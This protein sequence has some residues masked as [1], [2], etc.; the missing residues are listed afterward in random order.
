MA[1]L[2]TPA[3]AQILNAL[4][5]IVVAVLGAFG[6][7]LIAVLG[8]KLK[9]DKARTVALHVSEVAGE[10]VLELQQTMAE[11]MKAAAADGRITAE[12]AAELK[13]LAVA[14]VKRHIGEKGKADLLKVFGF[15]EKQLEAFIATKVEAG[16]V[17]ART[18]PEA[19]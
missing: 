3:A 10:V 11:G 4:V 2:Q 12:E 15:D 9:S 19:G 16:V 17:Q 13:E 18:K 5:P 7:W 6:S 14:R 1:F 8:S